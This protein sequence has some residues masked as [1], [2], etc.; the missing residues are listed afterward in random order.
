MGQEIKE[1]TGLCDSHEHVDP[2]QQTWRKTAGTGTGIHAGRGEDEAMPVVRGG[3]AH[4][5]AGVS[6]VQ[7]HWEGAGLNHTSRAAR[8]AIRAEPVRGRHG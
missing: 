5:A 1:A 7:V 8:A 6:G 4:C 3:A 2:A